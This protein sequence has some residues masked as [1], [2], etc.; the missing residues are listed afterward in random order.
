MNY[1]QKEEAAE[2]FRKAKCRLAQK[3]SREKRKDIQ[4]D[5]EKEEKSTVALRTMDQIPAMPG[6][7]FRPRMSPGDEYNFMDIPMQCL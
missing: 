3:R 5:M 6:G 1:T 4:K 2:G 7:G